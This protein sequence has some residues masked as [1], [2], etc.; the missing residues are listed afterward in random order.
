VLWRGMAGG[1]VKSCGVQ[2]RGVCWSGV[3]IPNHVVVWSAMTWT[4][5]GWG[6]ARWCEV[7]GRFSIIAANWRLISHDE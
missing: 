6:D 5:A 3:F 1:V 4:E 2:W 7:E